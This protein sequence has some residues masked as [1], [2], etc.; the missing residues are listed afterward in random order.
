MLQEN[1]QADGQPNLS[2]AVR[3]LYPFRSHFLNIDGLRY[4]YVDEGQGDP[5]LMVHGNPTWSFL[6]RNF[7]RAL[8]GPHRCLAVDHMGCGLSDKPQEYSYRLGRHIAN[9]EHLLLTLDLRN[10]TLMVHDWGGPIGLGA[11]V[12]HPERFRKIIISNSAGFLSQRMPAILKVARIPWLGEFLIRGL[13]AFVRTALYTALEHRERLT[14]AVRRGYLEPYNSWAN[15]IATCRFVQDVPMSADH[16]SHKTLA[17]LEQNLHKLA[18]LP[19]LLMWGE[20]DWCFPPHFRD[21]FQVYFPEAKRL[22]FPQAG[23]LLYEDE[24]EATL[25]GV[26]EFLA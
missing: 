16:P 10:V 9:L 26:Q 17:E 2:A 14:G 19:I 5:I 24:P 15:R 4:H 11:A 3:E 25:A 6:F 8:A 22:D 21:R 13:N 1:L 20:K 12:R 18:H 23:H 7:I